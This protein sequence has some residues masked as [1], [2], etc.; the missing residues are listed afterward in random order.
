MTLDTLAGATSHAVNIKHSRFLANAAP[1]FSPEAALAVAAASDVDATQN[2]WTMAMASR[3]SLLPSFPRRREPSD[4]RL[5]VKTSD[6]ASD[7]RLR[8]EA[9]HCIGFDGAPKA[10]RKVAGFS[11]SRE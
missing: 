6:Q 7:A 4:F 10:D 8:W 9:R 11:P 1:V 5:C 2:C 3:T